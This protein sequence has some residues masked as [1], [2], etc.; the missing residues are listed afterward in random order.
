[1][2]KRIQIAALVTAAIVLS[3]G[4]FVAGM[5]LGGSE[6]KA[7]ASAQGQGGARQQQTGAARAGGAGGA[8]GAGAAA[9]QGGG[10]VAGRVISVN[11]DGIT[12]EVRTPGS[13]QP[14][15]VIVLTGASS[16]IVKTTET[17]IKLSDIK[18]GDQVLVVGQTDAS[19]GTISATA[20]ID[21]FTA[22]QQLF[23][24][25]QGGARPGGTGSGA[26]RPSPSGSPRP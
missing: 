12:V 23:G 10:Q 14:R 1:M 24:G 9:G 26:P 2:N 4:G 3:G 22:L 8:S 19:T 17:D 18:P 7:D 13:D 11:N 15:S 16:R 6:A 5:T 20:V 25:G 21:G